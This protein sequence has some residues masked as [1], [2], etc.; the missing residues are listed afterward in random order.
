MSGW[1]SFV[2]TLLFLVFV[3]GA[4]AVIWPKATWEWITTTVTWLDNN[5]MR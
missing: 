3:L 5:Y 1:F 2:R 4:V